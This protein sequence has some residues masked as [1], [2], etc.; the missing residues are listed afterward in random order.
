M[1]Q[2]KEVSSWNSSKKGFGR[3]NPIVAYH[4]TWPVLTK[5]SR[6]KLFTGWMLGRVQSDSIWWFSWPTKPGRT[7][8]IRSDKRFG[9]VIRSD[10]TTSVLENCLTNLCPTHRDWILGQVRSKSCWIIEGIC[11]WSGWLSYLSFKSRIHMSACWSHDVLG[12]SLS[13]AA[14]ISSRDHLISFIKAASYVSNALKSKTKDRLRLRRR[15][16]AK[17]SSAKCWK[18][19]IWQSTSRSA[20][21]TT[22]IRRLK[23][24]WRRSNIL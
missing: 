17:Q 13:A 16:Q 20:T 6:N 1:I 15:R 23:K 24:H 10:A 19:E 22:K 2:T 12:P 7:E 11:V 3:S 9:L 4:Q 18:P 5:P 14:A 21:W 8:L